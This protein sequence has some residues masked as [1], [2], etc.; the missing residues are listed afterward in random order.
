MKTFFF[1]W[2]DGCQNFF[3]T[4]GERSDYLFSKPNCPCRKEGGYGGGTE[5]GGGETTQIFA[6]AVAV[7]ISFY[8]FYPSIFF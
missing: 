5:G 2:P 6:K 4:L 7:I 1:A 3:L 8:P